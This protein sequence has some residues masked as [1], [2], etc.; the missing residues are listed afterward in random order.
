MGE[1]IPPK[2]LRQF[3]LV[4]VLIEHADKQPQMSRLSWWK[5][6]TRWF[7]YHSIQV[8]WYFERRV[9]RLL[10]RRWGE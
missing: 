6:C 2:R 1:R 5:V 4:P 9:A 7:Q 8:R 10:H 3:T